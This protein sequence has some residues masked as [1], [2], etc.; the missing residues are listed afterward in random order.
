MQ[1]PQIIAE[2]GCNHKGD[3]NIAKEL[4]L[5]AKNA[6]A[7]IVKF[8]K[9]NNKELLS[10]EQYNAPHPN[11][12]NSYGK[13]YGEHREFLEFS[14]EQHKALK[15][16]CEQIGVIYST[17]IWDST[18]ALEII[19]LNPAFIKV[20]SACNTNYELLKILRDS[21]KGEIQISVGMSTNEEVESLIDFFG[22]RRKDIILYACT[23]GYPIKDS[24]ACLLEIVRLK[25]KF[26]GVKSIGYSGHHLGTTLDLAAF[27]LGATHLERHFTKDKTWKGTD[28]AAS[29]EP[30]ELKKL[31][32]DL[33]SIC[34]ALTY[35]NSEILEIE[36]AQREKLKFRGDK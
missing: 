28:H 24:E 14:L 13:T 12:I 36:K 32:S 6:G 3:F 2:I 23:S 7:K 22:N 15:E 18:S 16:F 17:S 4:I 1:K 25:E 11:P 20:P 35:K 8:Q 26:K 33:E 21:Y 29:L 34:R 5:L 30:D 10:K 19:S 31:V 27:M 9:R